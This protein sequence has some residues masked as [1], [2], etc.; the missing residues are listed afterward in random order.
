MEEVLLINY[1]GSKGG[2]ALYALEMTRA[3]INQ[4]ISC[5]AIVASHNESLEEWKQLPLKKLVI[6]DTYQSNKALLK[7]S[8]FWKKNRTYIKEQLSEYNV[9]AVFVP[10]ITF[11]SN[12]INNLYPK[13]KKNLVLHDPTP[14][15]GEFYYYIQ[16]LFGQQK[17]IKKADTVIVLSSNFIP[18]VEKEYDKKGHVLYLPMGDYDYY[19]NDIEGQEEIVYGDHSVNFIF[20]GRISKYKG[21]GELGKAYEEVTQI[22]NDVSLTVAGSGD[23]SNYEQMYAALPNITVVN[24]WIDNAEVKS[25]FKGKNLIA[26]LPYR[27]ATQSGVIQVCKSFGIPIIASNTGGLKEQLKDYQTAS[28]LVEPGDSNDLAG[29]MSEV[30]LDKDF[31]QMLYQNASEYVRS[32]NWENSAV[33]IKKNI[34]LKE[35]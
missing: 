33:E 7:K 9:A 29:K 34:N 31:R 22:T 21:L 35:G 8:I 26:V 1:T 20:F 4:N 25:F 6:I 17:L 14:H 5:V 2:G 16:N 19:D 15:S 13:A 30:L 18:I 32:N 12:R 24:R 10:M 23:F 11:W 28:V 27:D 3:F